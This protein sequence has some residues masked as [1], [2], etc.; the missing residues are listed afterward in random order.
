[1]QIGRRPSIFNFVLA[2]GL[3]AVLGG[4]ERASAQCAAADINHNGVVGG[5]DLAAL[6]G[7]WGTN[8]AAADLNNDGVVA[9]ADLAIVLG[10]W[11]PCGFGGYTGTFYRGVDYSPTW[12]GWV[13]GLALTQTHDSDFFND[14]FASLWANQ[15]QAAPP[16]SCSLPANNTIYRDDLGTIH[17][18]GFGLVRFYDLGPSRGTCTTSADPAPDHLNFL[19]Y[20]KTLGLTV[21]VPVSDYFLGNDQYSWNGWT[22]DNLYSF[23]SAPSNIQTSFTEFVSS[24]T[25]STTGHIHTAVHSIAIGNEGDLG[26][27]ISDGTTASQFLAR[28]N[29]WIY[30]LHQQINGAGPNGPNQLPVVNGSTG[31]LILLTAPMSNAD[32]GASR[33]GWWASLINGV[34]EAT[35]IPLG[36]P[37]WTGQNFTA[38]VT[39]LNSSTLTYRDW[40]TYYYNS[41]NIEQSG[42]GLLKSPMAQQLAQYDSN[43][44]SVWP[45]FNF[46]RSGSNTP[47]MLMEVSPPNQTNAQFS[48]T[49]AQAIEAYLAQYA[50]TTNLMGYNFFEFN[51]EPGLNKKWGL[52]DY[53]AGTFTN[54]NTGTTSTYYGTFPAMPFPVD[55]LTAVG[56]YPDSSQPLWKNWTDQFPTTHQGTA[57]ADT[58]IGSA[59]ADRLEGGAGNDII[60]GGAGF[61]IARFAQNANGYT[62]WATA[63]SATI[64]VQD[65]IGTEGTDTLTGVEQIR[66]AN[67][68]IDSASIIKAASLPAAQVLKVVDLYTAGLNRAPDALSLAFHAGRLAD[69]ASIGSIAKAIFD[70]A[71]AA[72]I[73]STANSNP[74]FV[75]LVYQNALGR[76]PDAAEL[77]YWVDKLNTG[78]LVRTDLVTSLVAGAQGTDAQYI[79]NKEAVGAHFALTAGLNNLAWAQAVVSAVNTTAASVTAANAQTDAFAAIAATAATSEL[80]V[81]IMGLVP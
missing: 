8:N 24:I 79:A 36:Y 52:Y 28:T 26:Q 80:V 76:A 31:A 54:A 41:L 69:G 11:G 15:F 21:V 50:S 7:H 23:G 13:Q 32:S 47:L 16:H 39:G 71:E 33:G 75:N 68:V 4:A 49:Q 57:S 42:D 12:S 73:Y 18:N 55:K 60:H 44:V 66:F 29:W 40:A 10:V 64:T 46:S 62:I 59:A 58:L 17:T 45:F 77:S 35:P 65:K 61:D 6:L 67:A 22:P 14:A 51:D 20:A 30:N 63:G 81:Q 48:V 74:V 19:N 37:G 9:G 38:A 34:T 2:S 56:G 53:S 1:M 5:E 25:D 27:G 72:P 3:I 70:S 78:Q 43:N